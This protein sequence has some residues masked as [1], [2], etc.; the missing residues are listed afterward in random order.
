MLLGTRFI[1]LSGDIQGGQ[2]FRGCGEGIAL[3]EIVI[4]TDI[5][6]YCVLFVLIVIAFADNGGVGR[7]FCELDNLDDVVQQL[8]VDRCHHDE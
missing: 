4:G 6:E 8:F 3:I 2:G 7:P 5:V 1:F